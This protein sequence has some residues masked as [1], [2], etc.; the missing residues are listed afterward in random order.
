M[1]QAKQVDSRDS[2][3][4]PLTNQL[5]EWFRVHQRP[6]P[7]RDDPSPYRVWVSEVMLQ[8][9]QVVTVIPYFERW[10]DRFADVATLASADESEILAMWSGLGY[11]RRARL[12]HRAAK[13][14][15]EEWGGR[16]PTSSAELL[17]LPG[18]GRYTAGAIASIAFG[19]RVAAVDGNV[20]RVATRLFA[21]ARPARTGSVQREIWSLIGDM[22]PASAPSEFNQALMELGSLVCTPRKPACGSCPL[23]EACKGREQGIQSSLP[24]LA[25]PKA[26]QVRPWWPPSRRPPWSIQNAVFLWPY[27]S[28]DNL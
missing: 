13:V 17:T 7:W 11:Y 2:P 16:L 8:Q 28:S 15:M 10:I 1:S 18:V 27:P 14:V 24:I 6:M 12:L 25:R 22:V 20:I 23:S 26:R 21:I 5:L 4:S 19:E 3:P 9:T